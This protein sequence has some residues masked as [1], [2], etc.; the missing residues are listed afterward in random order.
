MPKELRLTDEESIAL[1]ELQENVKNKI[2]LILR[3]K[4]TRRCLYPQC[5]PK[6]TTKCVF[7]IVCKTAENFN[8]GDISRSLER[9]AR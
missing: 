1:E 7:I 5:T 9:I 3:A 6:K 4:L 2:D 8:G